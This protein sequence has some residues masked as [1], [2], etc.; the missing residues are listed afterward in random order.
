MVDLLTWALGPTLF[1]FL[2]VFA[3]ILL[4]SSKYLVAGRKKMAPFFRN[5][6]GSVIVGLDQ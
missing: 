2:E 5:P 6:K 1:H 4:T 3:C